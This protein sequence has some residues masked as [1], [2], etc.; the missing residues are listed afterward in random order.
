MLEQL[1]G[2]GTL[3][4]QS[5][6]ND[7]LSPSSRVPAFVSAGEYMLIQKL[8]KIGC[9]VRLQRSGDRFLLVIYEPGRKAIRKSGRGAYP[10]ASAFEAWSRRRFPIGHIGA[11]ENG[12][13]K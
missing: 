11:A 10:V 12:D 2:E 5:R 13:E 3:M 7:Y 4:E 6:K 8:E 9:A 1:N